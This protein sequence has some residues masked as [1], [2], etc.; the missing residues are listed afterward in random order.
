MRSITKSNVTRLPS[1]VAASASLGVPV[2]PC[3]PNKRPYIKNNLNSATFDPYKIIEWWKKWPDA[4][5]GMPTG[6]LSGYVI[7]DVDDRDGEDGKPFKDGSG[8]LAKLEQEYGKLPDTWQTLTPSGGFHYWY[9]NPDIEV[10]NSQSKIGDG[11]DIRGNGGYVIISPSPG[12]ELEASNSKKCAVMPEWLTELC[13]ETIPK[14]KDKQKGK[15]AIID[16]IKR[17]GLSFHE[18][19]PVAHK[20]SGFPSG[21]Y[22]ADFIGWTIL[23]PKA[24]K[25]REGQTMI[26]MQFTVYASNRDFIV[27][28][29]HMVDILLL[30]KMKGN[31]CTG[32]RSLLAKNI[33]SL[34]GGLA[35][36]GFPIQLDLND[37]DLE[38]FSGKR[39]LVS[40]EDSKKELVGGKL[41][42]TKAGYAVIR[43]VQTSLKE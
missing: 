39:L 7:L 20:M 2:F 29:F 8:S 17:K 31:I 25:L 11:L 12:Y 36:D 26:E 18:R 21:Q 28:S 24:F 3:K 15:K 43:A 40:V 4:W 9:K 37:V 42:K 32:S 41:K 22:E 14:S 30:P 13:N 6:A 19:L 1:A 34:I 23:E 27:S 38:I 33:D 5:I 10:G 35:E 16:S